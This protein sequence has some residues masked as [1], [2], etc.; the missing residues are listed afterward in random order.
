MS[1]LYTVNQFLCVGAVCKVI[2]TSQ[3]P[4]SV[5]EWQRTGSRCTIRLVM[6]S[7]TIME[8]NALQVQ[9]QQVQD[10]VSI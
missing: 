5:R 1:N 10:P 4:F 2:Q 7:D 8:K 6:T 9:Q 3:Y